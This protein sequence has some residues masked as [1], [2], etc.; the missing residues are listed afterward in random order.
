MATIYEVSKLAGVSLATVSRVMNDPSKVSE[1]TQKKVLA[2]MQQLDYRPNTIAQSLA[3]NR[4]NCVGVLVSELHGP[5][6]G[7]MVS[8]IEEELTRAGKFTIFTAGH[9]DAATERKGIEFLAGRKCDALILHVEALHNE[10]FAERQNRL[11]PFVLLNRFAPGLEENCISLNNELGG[12]QATR[13]L[14]DIG[15]HQIAYISGPLEWSDAKAR[16]SGHQRALAEAR[17]EFEDDLLVEG[18]YHESGGVRAMQ[19]LLEL[20]RPITAVV[21]ANDEM[22][23]GAMEVIRNSG[24]SIPEDISVVGFD[25]VRWSKFLYPKLTTVEYPVAEMSRMAAKWVLKN[26][27]REPQVDLQYVF[28]PRLICRASAAA[29][30]QGQKPAPA[31]VAT[32]KKAGAGS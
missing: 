21:C 17:I 9:S 12:Y 26:V 14:L 31:Q 8:S 18:D 22:A 6:F 24:R 19:R 13:M 7:T 1:K 28:H 15:H 32:G 5:I 30:A 2:A 23:A 10:F 27:Y 20:G 11:L 3:S 16:L 4:S 29:P 25:N